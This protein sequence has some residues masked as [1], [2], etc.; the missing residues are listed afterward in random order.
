[1]A[2]RKAQNKYYPPEFFDSN[3]KSL[4]AFRN[5]KQKSTVRFELPFDIVCTNCSGYFS[6]GVRYNAIKKQVG[7]YLSTKI[8]EFEMKCKSCDGWYKIRTDPEHAEYICYEG[9]RRNINSIREPSVLIKDQEE[10]DAMQLL[11]RKVEDEQKGT[12]SKTELQQILDYNDKR[13]DIYTNNKRLRTELRLKDQKESEQDSLGFK[14]ASAP[15][16]K[17]V[18]SSSIFPETAQS[19]EAILKKKKKINIPKISSL[20]GLQKKI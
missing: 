1:M 9:L 14:S 17:Q 19:I 13:K 10:L 7:E 11:E 16:L 12:D 6:M 20:P 5:N 8:Y 15:S 3:H 2:E 4:N 18:K